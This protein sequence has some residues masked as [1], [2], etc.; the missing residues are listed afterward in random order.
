[1]GRK[2]HDFLSKTFVQECLKV[3]QGN[4]LMCH[5]FRVAK[6]FMLQRV[7]SRFYRRKFFFTVSKIS[8]EK[9][10][11]VVFQKNSGIQKVYG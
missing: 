8:S 2:Y 9:P 10:L 4:L 3:S 6:N 11:C 1:M 5:Q 7:K